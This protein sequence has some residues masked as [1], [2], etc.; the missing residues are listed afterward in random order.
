MQRYDDVV[1]GGGHNGLTAAAYLSRAGRRVLVLEAL[2]RV[3][4][5]AVSAPVFTGVDVR[6][7]RYSYL[8]SLL[9]RRIVEDLA[10]PLTLRRRT[11]GSYTPV[12]ADPRR[13]LLVGGP[14]PAAADARFAA[15]AGGDAAGWTEF[16]QR[17]G[18]LARG[19]W[20]T[21]LQPLRPADEVRA[22]S[23]DPELFDLLTTVPLGE[24]LRRFLTDDLTVGIAATDGLIGTFASLADPSLVQNVCF[25]YHVVGGGTGD[26]DVPVG[27]MG[28][29]AAALERAAYRGGAE[30]RTGCPVVAVTPDGE[31]SFVDDGTVCRVRASRVVAGCA[32]TTLDGLLAAA[33]APPA[34]GPA[35]APEGA[36]LKVNMVLTR[37]PRLRDRQVS[38]EQAF[39]GT[40][41]VN[42]SASQLE[43]AYRAALAGRLPDPVP[44]EVY[45]HTLADRSILGPGLAASGAQTLTLFAL[46]L[47][48]R[49]F[50]TDHDAMRARAL[51]GCLRSLESVLAEPVE[52]LLLRGPDGRPCIEARTPLDLQA[53]LGLPGGHIFHRALRWPWAQTPAEVGTWGV[54]TAHPAIRLA[55][56][57]ARRGGGVSGIPGHLAAQ[58]ILAEQPPRPAT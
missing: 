23:G 51:A 43:A 20:P 56:A 36:Q 1:V 3:G 39:A 37:L 12:P 53:D 50:A 33:G 41:H 35:E 40:L 26:W 27:G 54:E 44:C 34:G 4:G 7:S 11:Y 42:E 14:D 58:S 13:G 2:D 24:V 16:Y 22:A 18:G 48:A 29:L 17:V 45:C 38:A 55:C 8:V 25:L 6:L 46:Q 5:A 28:A 21:V 31:V 15:V 49:L 47:P 52:P 9:P 30:L 32:P 19:I 57:G 10:L